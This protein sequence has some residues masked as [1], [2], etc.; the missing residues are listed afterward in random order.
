MPAPTVSFV[1]SSIRMKEP[2]LRLRTYSSTMSGSAR[3]RRTTPRSLSS[4]LS[5]A[6]PVLERMDVDDAEDL[7]DAGG[8]GS[9]RVLDEKTVAG[10]DR[11][12]GHPADARGH[13]ACD[14][15]RP[16]GIGEQVPAGDV[17]VVLE[18]D[19][20]R[21]ARDRLL[22]E[23]VGAVDRGDAAPEAGRQDDD[24]V[25]R[26]PHATGDATGIAPVVVV[27]I[28]HRPDHPLHR[29]ASI[30]ARSGRRPARSSRGARAA[31]TRHTTG[32]SSRGSRRCRPEAPTGGSP[33]RP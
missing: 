4:S 25:A 27:L 20:H 12:L 28:G 1:D 14:G 21:L 24:L 33:P 7:V 3:R 5:G 23:T 16:F 29:E 8:N 31:S 30:L 32:S 26:L 6:R 9:R 17:D 10:R 15:R 13:L 2:V 19:R 18:E 22:A 11:P